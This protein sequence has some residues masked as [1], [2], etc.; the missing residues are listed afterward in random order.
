MSVVDHATLL[1][2]LKNNGWMFRTFYDVGANIGGWT[3]EVRRVFPE[4]RFELFEP[5]AGRFPELDGASLWDK[6]DNCGFHA[7]AL[8]NQNGTTRMK[9]LGSRGVG[10]SIVLLEADARKPLVFVDVPMRRMDDIARDEHLPPPDFIKLDVQ[11]AELKVLEG[12]P[13]CLASAQMVLVET[14][15]R[16]VYGPETPL[17]HEIAA[18]L[19]RQNYVMF[20]LLLAADGRD[21]NG[22][23]RWFDAVFVNKRFSSHPTSLL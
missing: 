15:A 14:W 12:A 18:F 1:D 4:A 13:E 7:V 16:R 21:P 8:S 22:D 10:S 2:R 6:L 3:R 11:A 17:F 9:L 5:L 20:D 23:L 19:Y